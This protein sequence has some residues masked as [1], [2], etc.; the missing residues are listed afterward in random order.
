LG[1]QKIVNTPSKE[2]ENTMDTD[3]NDKGWVGLECV[4]ELPQM[5]IC[6]AL[7]NP[8]LQN[9]HRMI[10]ANMCTEEQANN[11]QK[12]LLKMFKEYYESTMDVEDMCDVKMSG[13]NAYDV[14]I[15][16]KKQSVKTALEKAEAEIALF[17]YNNNQ[18]FQPKMKPYKTLGLTEGDFQPV[19]PVYEIGPVIS[20]GKNFEKKINHADYV[21]NAGDYDICR[22]LT[23]CKHIYPAG[24]AVFN[25]KLAHHVTAEVDCESLFSQA[26]Y[27]AE[28]RR[29]LTGIRTYERLVI[30]KHRLHRIHIRKEDVKKLYLER[31]HNKDWDEGEDRDDQ[32]F[33]ELEGEL[34]ATMFPQS[35][36]LVQDAD[37]EDAEDETVAGKQEN[38]LSKNGD[39]ESVPQAEVVEIDEEDEQS[40]I[41]SASVRFETMPLP[42]GP[43][44]PKAKE[45]ELFGD[46]S[47]EN[48]ED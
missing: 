10:V 40:D 3:I 13:D 24:E 23:D 15:S 12:A 34:W 30:A 19:K 22:M 18:M 43:V 32:A 37:V 39:D 26:G 1:Y 29:S 44:S 33:L 35:A 25:G 17:M 48:D 27:V 46:S 45:N 11:G 38:D 8:L 47:S 28:P 41:S 42:D 7:M 36:C 16:Y 5:K 21:D 2:E 31:F 4:A 9:V 14:D 6:G 20:R